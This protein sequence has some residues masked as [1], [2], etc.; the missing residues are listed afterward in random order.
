MFGWL[1]R[2]PK[3]LAEQRQLLLPVIAD[4]PLYQPPHRQGPNFLR[5]TLD[6]SEEAY[7]KTIPEFVARADE[8][9]AYFMEQRASR[10][11]SLKLFLAKLGVS[12]DFDDAGLA[13]LSH[14]FPQNSFALVPSLRDW[15]VGQMFYQMKTPWIGELRGLNVI[16]D[17]GI[18]L[19]ECLTTRQ[20]RLHW[21]R[22]TGSSDTGE[23]YGTGYAIEGFK[24]HAKSNQ[25]DPSERI[26]LLCKNDLNAIH[27]GQPVTLPNALSGIVRGYS[28]R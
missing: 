2:E 9:F 1:K 5:R 8:N 15:T 13:S 18:F 20:P 26:F 10:V 27:S 21:R 22:Y 17:L 6:Q 23:A 4:Y 12:A 3:Q 28:M 19:G 24:R 7:L 25:F 11:A 14:W 16:F